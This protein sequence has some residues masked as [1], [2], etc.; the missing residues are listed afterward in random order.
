MKTE[1]LIATK[2]IVTTYNQSTII[3]D[4]KGNIKTTLN[5]YNQ[6][7]KGTKEMQLKGE[8][9]KLRWNK[10]IYLKQ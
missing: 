8:I 9:V 10:T 3:T 4:N 1:T 7:R 6:P 2:H 5:G